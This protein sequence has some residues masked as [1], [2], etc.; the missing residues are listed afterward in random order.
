MRVPA[1]H[2]PLGA[3]DRTGRKVY[4]DGTHRT[5]APPRT[6]AHVKPHMAAMGITR[7]ANLTGLDRLG[8][9][10]VGVFRP[11]S[12]SVAVAQGK[13][14]HL[15]AAKAS[16]LMEAVETFHAETVG[17]TLTASLEALRRTDRVI[18]ISRL[19]QIP[20]VALPPD[21][22]VPWIR[23][24]DWV[25]GAPLFVPYELVSTDYTLPL[26]AGTGYAS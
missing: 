24:Q 19:P 23:A 11:N 17:A 16:G 26:P 5:E 20:D 14:L 6:L 12:R 9:P 8:I 1:S 7:I 2:M 10:V 4:R 21:Q 15:D 22:P 3:S 13:G 25:S 18:D